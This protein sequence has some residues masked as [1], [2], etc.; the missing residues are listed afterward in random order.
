MRTHE[1]TFY[2]AVN[3]SRATALAVATSMADTAGWDITGGSAYGLTDGGEGAAKA[4]ATAATARDATASGSPGSGYAVASGRA[5]DT[6]STADGWK[7]IW[8]LNETSMEAWT[9]AND[10]VA[11]AT[12]L[13]WVKARDVTLAVDAWHTK[14]TNNQVSGAEMTVGSQATTE[15]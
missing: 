13:W 2:G 7:T 12:S 10:S 1:Q 4:L 9:T 3:T 11:G 8:T 14:W 15:V 6:S 5:Q